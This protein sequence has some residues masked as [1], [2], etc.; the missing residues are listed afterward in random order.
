[1]GE[2]LERLRRL[3]GKQKVLLALLGAGLVLTDIAFCMDHIVPVT[4]AMIF[5][6]AMGVW[7]WK[8]R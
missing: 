5:T 4:A 8:I 1:V 2:I 7:L 6:V 3:T